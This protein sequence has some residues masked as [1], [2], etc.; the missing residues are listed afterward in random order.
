MRLYLDALSYSR[1]HPTELVAYKRITGIGA[2]VNYGAF[3]NSK[4]HGIFSWHDRRGK[5]N[6]K[7]FKRNGMSH[8]EYMLFNDSGDVTIHSMY[9][10]GAI[11]EALSSMLCDERD[12]AFYV[13]LALYGIDKE[14]TF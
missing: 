13:T 1:E 5:L 9:C 4:Q 6:C 10:N 14:Y 12:D 7:H 2:G 11:I 3:L 8:G